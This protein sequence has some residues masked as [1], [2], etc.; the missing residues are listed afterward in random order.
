MQCYFCTG[1][2]SEHNYYVIV[3][4][5]LQ[6][7]K[8]SKEFFEVFILKGVFWF[9]IGVRKIFKNHYPL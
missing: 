2:N 4:H 6:P 8:Y 3:V 5:H 7:L 9:N 1:K